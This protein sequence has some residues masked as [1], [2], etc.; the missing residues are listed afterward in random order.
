MNW[1]KKN[2]I[3]SFYYKWAGNLLSFPDAEDPDGVKSKE[4]NLLL[5]HSLQTRVP[6]KSTNFAATSLTI[7]LI[8]K[9]CSVRIISLF[10]SST[11][12]FCWLT[13]ERMRPVSY[14][15]FVFEGHLPTNGSGQDNN[16]KSGFN[17]HIIESQGSKLIWLLVWIR[18]KYKSIDHIHYFLQNLQLSYGSS[19]V[20]PYVAIIFHPVCG[21]CIS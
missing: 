15:H 2:W 19:V 18:K 3:C 20:S 13:A 6:H 7:E 9:Y 1:G 8:K 10:I 5:L 16:F 17:E 14:A 11:I 4:N 21:Q 12:E